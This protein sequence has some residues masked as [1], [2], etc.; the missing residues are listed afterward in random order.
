MVPYSNKITKTEGWYGEVN[1]SS[2]QDFKIR[3]AELLMPA[4]EGMRGFSEFF[5]R[6]QSCKSWRLT[7]ALD[8]KFKQLSESDK[9][10]FYEKTIN[11]FRKALKTYGSLSANL[12]PVSKDFELA[13]DEIV[14]ALAQHYGVPT[15]LLDWS[16]SLY[17]AAFFAFSSVEF[18]TSGEVSIF[19]LSKKSERILEGH[20]S[21]LRDIYRENERQL[22]QSG[23]FIANNT[24]YGDFCDVFREENRF[25]KRSDES[26]RGIFL[27]KFSLPKAAMQ[28]ASA[29]LEMMRINAIT[30]FPGLEGIAMWMRDGGVELS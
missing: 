7:S 9:K 19:A 5:Y 6:G 12:K 23:V 22:W 3:S 20:C 24:E 17:V 13:N 29:D 1:C 25:F 16:E 27:I 4:G 26:S 30:L 14:A 21:I 18:C 28:E 10:Q 11:T 2:W 8:R 15:R